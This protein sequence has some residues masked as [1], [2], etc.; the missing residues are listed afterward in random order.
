[1]YAVKVPRRKREPLPKPDKRA[2]IKPRAA[3][4]GRANDTKIF[5]VAACSVLLEAVKLGASQSDAARA[6]GVSPRTVRAWLERGRKDNAEVDRWRA[7]D[8][9]DAKP[10]PERTAYGLFV[11]EWLKAQADPRL[12]L[13]RVVWSSLDDLD[14]QP[15]ERAALAI[16]MLERLA[17]ADYSAVTNVRTVTT[18]DET[19]ERVDSAPGSAVLAKLEEQVR[20][21]EAIEAAARGGGS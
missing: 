16:K 8:W 13:L 6:L 7:G 2:A 5:G 10:P 1:M 14:D 21:I 9:P 11:E 12:R 3:E 18:D 4:E 19:G 20:R 15:K 17:P